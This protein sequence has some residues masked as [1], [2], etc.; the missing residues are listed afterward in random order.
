MG[1]FLVSPVTMLTLLAKNVPLYKRGCTAYLN[2]SITGSSVLQMTVIAQYEF[3]IE[4]T[5]V[6]Y[7]LS[8]Y[9]ELYS[10]GSRC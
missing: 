4:D 2:R 8:K 5:S 9:F 6:I 3:H 7:S 10:Q 1:P